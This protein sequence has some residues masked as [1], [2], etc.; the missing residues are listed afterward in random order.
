[1]NRNLDPDSEASG[2]NVRKARKLRRWLLIFVAVY[3]GMIILRSLLRMP[4]PAALDAV[5]LKSSGS[6]QP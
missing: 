3:L 2:M 4:E 5:P 6:N 1:M